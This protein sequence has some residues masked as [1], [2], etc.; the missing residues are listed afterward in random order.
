VFQEFSD[1]R[2][3]FTDC[4]SYIV[5]RRLMLPTAVSLDHHFRQ[6]GNCRVVPEV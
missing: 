5:I 1:K 3:S 6:F 4:I 2:W